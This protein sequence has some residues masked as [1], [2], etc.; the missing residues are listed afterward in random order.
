M[1]SAHGARTH[2]FT[3]FHDVHFLILFYCSMTER[4][5]DCLFKKKGGN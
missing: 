5:D 3:H 4:Y 2:T 1:V